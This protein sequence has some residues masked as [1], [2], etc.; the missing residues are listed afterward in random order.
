MT[1]YQQ[2]YQSVLNRILRPQLRLKNNAHLIIRA[3]EQGHDFETIKHLL[4]FTPQTQSLS[5][6]QRRKNL[7][8][9]L[10]FAKVIS[11]NYING[12]D[13]RLR[14]ELND[15][16]YISLSKIFFCLFASSTVTDKEKGI[17]SSVLHENNLAAYYYT[18]RRI[19]VI[20]DADNINLEYLCAHQHKVQNYGGGWCIHV[21]S[22]NFSLALKLK[23][24]REFCKSYYKIY[25]FSQDW[26]EQYDQRYLRMVLRLESRYSSLSLEQAKIAEIA[27]ATPDDRVKIVREYFDII[28]PDW[29]LHL[30]QM[31]KLGIVADYWLSVCVKENRSNLVQTAID[32]YRQKTKKRNF[33]R[34]P[35][36]Y[37]RYILNNLDCV[38]EYD[39]YTN[40]CSA[41]TW[42]GTLDRLLWGKNNNIL[43]FLTLECG[44]Y[45]FSE[46]SNNNYTPK[47]GSVN[48][49][50]EVEVGQTLTIQTEIDILGNSRI[51]KAE[52]V[53]A[54]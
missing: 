34:N 17:F 8:D 35:I 19:L 23:I 47:M 40:D 22:D 33:V 46:Y 52:I 12:E 39:G 41:G 10:A 3:V 25:P 18:T 1:T 37:W 38:T 26:L 42:Q 4:P 6:Q 28:N 31:E 27:G 29:P 13:Y 30:Q 7:Q 44:R 24:W 45:Y 53:R 21:I 5:F 2:D 14:F 50:R 9:C 16:V 32:I 54:A 15:E 43:V 20:H 49:A 51:V 36:A 48:L 11:D